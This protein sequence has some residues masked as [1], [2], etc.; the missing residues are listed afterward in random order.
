LA[1]LAGALGVALAWTLPGPILRSAVGEISLRLQP[2]TTVLAYTLGLS[3]LACFACG[4]AP[5]LAVTRTCRRGHVSLRSSLL[6]LQ[7][8]VS[9][10]L[11]VGAGLLVRGIQHARAADPGFDATDTASVS[12][13][14]PASAYPTPATHAFFQALSQNLRNAPG[15]QPFG[16]SDLEPLSNVRGFT[17]FRLPG[18]RE[19][20]ARMALQSSVSPGFFEILRIPILAG[21]NFDTGDSAAGT[22]VLV[23]QAFVSQ[24]FADGQALA[25]TIVSGGEKQIVGIV[26]NAHTAGLDAVDPMI[27][28][29]ANFGAAP[30][31]IVRNRPDVLAAVTALVHEMEPRARV[32]SPPLAQNLDRWL[33]SSRIGAAIAGMLGVLALALATIGIAGVFAYTVEQRKKEIGI[34]VALGA[35]PSQLVGAVFGSAARSLAVGL[36]LGVLGAFLASSMLRRYLFGIS[37]LDSVTYVAVLGTLALAGLAATYL[38]ARRVAAVD[39]METLRQD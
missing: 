9:V 33:S 26:R 32:S 36:L 19:D 16:W 15:A 34:R 14:L 6:A 30:R 7:V 21:R 28:V 11:L 2:D 23:N 20:Q 38:P 29:P 27:Y 35:H 25:K 3:L 31:L 24:Y 4:L 10:I 18:Q 17:S 8:G 5:A 37:R 13:D 1:V 22:A 12:I 39:P